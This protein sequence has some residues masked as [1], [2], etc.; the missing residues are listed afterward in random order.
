MSK[1]LWLGDAGCHTGFGRVTHSI[2]E[3]LA[4]EYGHQVHV[5][6]V[7]HLG[8]DFESMVYPGEK[9]PLWLYRPNTIVGSDTYGQSRIIELLGK[10]EP[11]VVVMLGDPAVVLDL[12][13]RNQYD[14]QKI[15]LQYRPILSYLPIDGYNQPMNWPNTLTAVT[16]V[17][18]MSNFGR[19][20]YPGSKLVYHGVDQSQFWPVSSR[21]IVL[22]DGR[23][24][25]T[26]KECKEAFGFD[27]EGFL[28]LRV[29]KNSGRKDFAATWHA[30]RPVMVR[31]RDIQ[32]H[33][34]CKASDAGSGI[35][36]PVLFNREPRIDKQ[37]YFF[38]DL[39][40]TFIGWSQVEMNALYNAADVF[41]ST[42]RGEGF[43]LTLLE[44]IA[45]GVPVIAQN[46]SAIPEVVGPGGVL[47]E[48]GRLL[49]VPSGQDVYL[50]DVEAFSEAIEQL[51][52][53]RGA[54]RD[55]GER[56]AEHA[57]QFSWDYA[58]ARFHEYIEVLKH[59]S[60]R[61]GNPDEAG[62][63]GAASGDHVQDVH[64]AAEGGNAS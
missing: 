10:I 45:C 28:V 1:V 21:P 30:L 32:V 2:G 19:V 20:T 14:Q 17:V 18:A 34:H 8:D 7:N 57:R 49:T 31:H 4:I 51:Y 50:A 56:G 63:A 22:P 54:R 26:K 6:A 44:A 35:N 62:A 64:G 3:R 41:V 61:S 46:V 60:D 23:K 25:T 55:L 52:E 43:G 29:D 39:H 9:T 13:Y 16:N 33:F 53:S 48:P 38:P 37:R 59:G 15:L 36:L 11:D 58:A 42:S 24:L 47:I 27:P 12:L 5:L 40:N